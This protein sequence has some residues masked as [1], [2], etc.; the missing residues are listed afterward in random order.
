MSIISILKNEFRLRNM[1]TSTKLLPTLETLANNMTDS[2][3]LYANND[4]AK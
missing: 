1:S 2:V 3:W 4:I